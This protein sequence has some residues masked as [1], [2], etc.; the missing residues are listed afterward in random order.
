MFTQNFLKLLKESSCHLQHF[1]PQAAK[2]ALK[3]TYKTYKQI[4]GDPN[5]TL[6]LDFYIIRM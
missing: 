5:L 4:L 2:F 3:D 6:I 1:L